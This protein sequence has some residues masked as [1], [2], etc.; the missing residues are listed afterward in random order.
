[1][2]DIYAIAYVGQVVSLGC[3]IWSILLWMGMVK[4]LNAV[5]GNLA[6]WPWAVYWVPLVW[7]YTIYYLLLV[8]P[9]DVQRVKQQ[10]GVQR[11]AR[12]LILYWFFPLWALASDLNDM[13]EPGGAAP[14]Q[15]M[16]GVPG[17]PGMR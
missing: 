9:K 8:V 10:N 3:Y 17:M 7:F 1:V 6:W 16:P 15:M 2:L 4:E 5:G 11:P 14:P 12:N 13:A